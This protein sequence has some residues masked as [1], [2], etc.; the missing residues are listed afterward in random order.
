MFYSFIYSQHVCLQIMKHIHRAIAEACL[1]GNKNLP[2]AVVCKIYRVAVRI[3]VIHQCLYNAL[4]VIKSYN[5]RA[6]LHYL[7]R[8]PEKALRHILMSAYSYG[9]IAYSQFLHYIQY[10]IGKSIGYIF[11]RDIPAAQQDILIMLG[12]SAALY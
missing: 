4:F 10:Q 11:A 2:A 3:A 9:K 8:P 12:V 7:R 5:A 6:V 1:A